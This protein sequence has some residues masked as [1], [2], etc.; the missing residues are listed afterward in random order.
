MFR[1]IEDNSISLDFSISGLRFEANLTAGTALSGGWFSK[2]LMS[3]PGPLISDFVTHEKDFHYSTYGIHV[4]Q[5]DRLT[6]MGDSRT[7]IDGFFVDCREGSATLHQIV[8][9]RFKPSLERRLVIPRG[10]AHT[11]DNLEGIVTRDEPVWYVDHDNPAW[12]LDND[13]VSVARSS[14]LNA[15]PIVRPNRHMLPDKAHIFLSK[16][17]QSLLENPKSYLAR[18]SVQIAGSQKFVMLEPKHWADDNRAVEL[19]IEKFKIPG[20]KA[21]RN[22]Y[23]FTGGKSFTLVPNTHACVADVLLLKANSAELSAYRWHARTRKIYTFLNNE[24]AEIELSFIDLR[25]DSD[26]FGQ[27]AHDTLICDP[28]VNITIEQGIAYCIRSTLDIYLRCEH[29]IFADENEPR[30]DIPM[31]GQDLISLSNDLP[32][33]K[34]SLPALQCPHSVVY[35]MAKFEQQN[36]S[37]N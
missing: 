6:F 36:F 29:E 13:L 9:L 7:Q 23:A 33:P 31:F 32:F 10:V 16:I 14:K 20:V 1:K 11:F 4:G 37:L 30:T 21:K 28:R 22:H 12:N 25:N 8:R 17:S 15:F 3:S 5:D 24:G 26:T 34:V 18:F 2:K 35:K 19:I 27:V